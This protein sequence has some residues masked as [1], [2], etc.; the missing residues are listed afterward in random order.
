MT[1]APYITRAAPLT[2]TPLALND[3]TYKMDHP[4]EGWL[5]SVQWEKDIVTSPF[6]HGDFLINAVKKQTSITPRILV[7][8][9]SEADVT[10]KVNTLIAAF[11]QFSYSVVYVK[12]TLEVTFLCQPA[13]YLAD[14]RWLL[15]EDNSYVMPVS[16]V[17]P[18]H[19]NYV[20]T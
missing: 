2:A 20:V 13:D 4:A 9:S 12:N 17:C 10:G 19:P 14:Y 3:A 6:Y 8:G 11:S 18:S 1:W 7:F 16:F 5:G 15:Y